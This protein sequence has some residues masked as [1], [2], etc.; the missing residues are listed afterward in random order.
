LSA[1][2]RATDLAALGGMYQG[3]AVSGTC[4]H[5]QR[6][7]LFEAGRPMVED[8]GAE[9]LVLAGTAAYSQPRPS[10]SRSRPNSSQ[11]TTRTVP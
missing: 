8:Q 6:A 10:L 5:E 1:R 11:P 7:T 3:T 4:T 9:A 2:P